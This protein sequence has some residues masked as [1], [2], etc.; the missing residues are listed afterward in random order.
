MRWACAMTASDPPP[1]LIMILPLS[2]PFPAR[3]AGA[4]LRW[5]PAA[6]AFGASLLLSAALGLAPRDAHRLAAVFPPWWSGERTL[7]AAGDLA[8]VTPGGL[9][10]IV[11]ASSARPDLAAALKAAGALFVVDGRFFAFCAPPGKI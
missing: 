1:G 11:A 5:A 3:R 6:L 10:F 8:D 2:K 4:L 7:A 9:R